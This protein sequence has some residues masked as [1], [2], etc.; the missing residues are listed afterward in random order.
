MPDTHYSLLGADQEHGQTSFVGLPQIMLSEIIEHSLVKF[1]PEGYLHLLPYK[2]WHA[3][4]LAD[5][6]YT[7]Q[8]EKYHQSNVD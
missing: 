3:W 7:E 4:C 8:A 2:L 1:V 6:G 5:Y